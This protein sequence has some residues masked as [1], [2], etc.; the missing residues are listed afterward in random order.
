MRILESCLR[1]DN[2]LQA[3]ILAD[4][5]GTYWV[6]AN[7]QTV[8]FRLPGDT[9]PSEHRRLSMGFLKKTY[10]F[11]LVIALVMAF[12]CKIP[13]SATSINATI[14]ISGKS[15]K[16]NYDYNATTR[17]LIKKFPVT[18]VL[19]ELNGNEKYKYLSYE[20]PTDEKAVKQIKAGDIMLYGSNCIVIFYKSFE[21]EYEYTY[22]G[23]I[24]DVS[25][26]EE[27]LG[28]GSVRVTFNSDSKQIKLNKNN[29]S[30]KKGKSYKLK[31]KNATSNKIKWISTDKKI[32]TVSKNGK[33]RAKKKG[34][35]II[36]A[37]YKKKKYKCK[38]T[39][40]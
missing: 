13:S 39:V 11:F 27:S 23:H 16:V 7:G 25:G 10:T 29:I 26:L 6:E 4:E 36:Q 2:M 24:N 8:H 9:D 31:L 15:F 37:V 22:L 34:N 35:V 14:E 12:S 40:R 21:T 1:G 3:S 19:S 5:E 32:A 38:V 33:I 28:K 17:A 20:L 18:Y 30:I